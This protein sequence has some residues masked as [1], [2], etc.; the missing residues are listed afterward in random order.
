MIKKDFLFSVINNWQFLA[1]ATSELDSASEESLTAQIEAII[2][3]PYSKLTSAEQKV[4]LE[5]EANEMLVQMNKSKT[6][7]PLKP[8]K[9]WRFIKDQF[10]WHFQ[11]KNDNEIEDILNV[12]VYGVYTWNNSTKIWVKTAST[13][14]LKFVFL[15]KQ[16]KLLTMHLYLPKA[17]LQTLK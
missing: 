14:E 13:T 6:S 7:G 8:F 4:K 15:Q 11:W 3:Q 17:T 2:K 5:A 10:C 1:P 16:L 12:G 9:I